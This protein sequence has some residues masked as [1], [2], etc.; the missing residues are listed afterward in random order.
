MQRLTEFLSGVSTVFCANEEDVEWK[1][2]LIRI[3]FRILLGGVKVLWVTSF[4]L[5]L[6]KWLVERG[7]EIRNGLNRIH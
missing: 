6:K 1:Q 2:N 7:V 5:L 3:S 4:K